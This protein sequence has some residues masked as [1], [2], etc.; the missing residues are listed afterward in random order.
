MSIQL[1]L[2]DSSSHAS[3]AARQS[4]QP[5]FTEGTIG[6]AERLLNIALNLA[7][8]IAQHSHGKDRKSKESNRSSRGGFSMLHPTAHVQ[9]YSTAFRNLEILSVLEFTHELVRDEFQRLAQ[10]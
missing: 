1:P 3:H 5:L 9:T 2:D 7:L 6:N 4:T 8:N 10:H